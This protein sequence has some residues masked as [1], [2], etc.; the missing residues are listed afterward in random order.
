M[1]NDAEKVIPFG[2]ASCHHERAGVAARSIRTSR[3]GRS[4]PQANGRPSCAIALLFPIDWEEPF[5]LVMVESLACGT[6]VVAYRRGAV[7]EVIEDGRTGFIV[8]HQSAAVDAV[9][10]IGAVDR[11]RCREAFET[12]FTAAR[13][14]VD[15]LRLY[16]RLIRRRQD[17]EARLV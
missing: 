1:S 7:A 13:M 15:Y 11:R 3:P 16:D 12:R 6:P 14:A 4:D 8:E 10:Q 5:E 9:R 2:R 17:P